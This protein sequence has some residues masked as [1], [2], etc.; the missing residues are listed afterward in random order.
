MLYNNSA[1]ILTVLI[2][3][4]DKMRRNKS[5]IS[6]IVLVITIIVMIILAGSIIISLSNSGIIG[7]SQEAVDAAN[8]QEIQQIA[9]LAWADAYMDMLDGET[10]NFED[11]VKQALID[12]KVDVD[13]YTITVTDNGVEVTE[14]DTSG[15]VETLKG[16]W[17]FKEAPNWGNNTYEYNVSFKCGGTTYSKLK[18]NANPYAADGAPG[19]GEMYYDDTLVYGGISDTQ[20]N[21][22]VD[23]YKTIE[24]KSA[25]KDVENAAQL[26]TWLEA[27]AVKQ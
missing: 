18:L 1:V 8:L 27:N 3:R 24:I 21:G 22:D 6:L 15:Y 9:T 4:K 7:K 23:A 13:K 16:V 12:N 14:K 5:G 10:V 11:R 26:L 17:T 19:P 20:W 2:E 25:Y